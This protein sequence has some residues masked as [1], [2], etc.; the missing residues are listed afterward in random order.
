MRLGPNEPCPLPSDPLLAKWAAALNA[1]GHWAEVYDADWHALYMTDEGRRIYGRGSG[2]APYIVGV[3]LLSAEAVDLMLGWPG[4]QYPLPVIRETARMFFPWLLAEGG[5][6]REQLRAQADP[7]LHDIVDATEAL[8]PPDAWSYLFRGV[9]TAAGASVEVPIAFFRVRDDAGR[10]VGV[11]QVGKPA[12]GMSVLTRMT[13]LG[14]RGH[15]DR[16]DRVA[17][18]GRR[19]AAVLFADLESSSSLARRLSTSSYFALIRRLARA[20]DESVVQAGGLIGQHAGDGVVAFFL[21][22]TAGSESAAARACIA[23]ARGV[24]QALPAVAER[25]ELAPADVVLRYGLHWGANLYVGQIATTGR[26]EVTA[27]GDQVNEAARVEACATGGRTLATK[28]LV[29]R[30]DEA[31]AAAVGVDLSHVTYTRLADLPTATEKARRDAPALAVCE[32]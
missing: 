8:A 22:E 20:A 7:R 31:D 32:L 10:I 16:V 2:L 6:N 1:T 4:G 26:T 24:Q 13:S 5:G 19:A 27:L 21:A 29:E 11:A 9:Y 18:P 25:C 12:V 17:S 23:A 28:D 15:F 3:R 30:L 14:D